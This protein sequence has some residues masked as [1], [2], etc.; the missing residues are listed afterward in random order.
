MNWRGRNRA[1]IL[2][3][4]AFVLLAA[5]LTIVYQRVAPGK[6]VEQLLGP[7]AGFTQHP[8]LPWLVGQFAPSWSLRLLATNEMAQLSALPSHRTRIVI[9]GSPTC[10]ATAALLQDLN[11][12]G[13]ALAEGA[14]IFLI[15]DTTLEGEVPIPE[16]L[17]LARQYHLAEDP[18]YSRVFP[19]VWVMDGSS[20]ILY[21]AR[22]YTPD[23][24]AT[25]AAVV[26]QGAN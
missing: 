9:L 24:I 21:D 18:P 2:G 22:G 20:R 10:E 23:A 17:P 1:L 3:F 13:E 11:K 15:W 4:L 7:A 16:T 25:L 5:G 14:D 8:H 26:N 12:D 19:T 6:S